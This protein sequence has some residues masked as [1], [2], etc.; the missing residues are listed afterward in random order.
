MPKR[1]SAKEMRE[2]LVWAFVSFRM[3]AEHSLTPS[4]KRIATERA[5]NCLWA[6]G[7]D[8]SHGFSAV[9]PEPIGDTIYPASRNP[10]H[11]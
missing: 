2:V 9:R 7:I 5:G 3:L 6:L 11:E 4:Q 8:Q 1:R 10:T